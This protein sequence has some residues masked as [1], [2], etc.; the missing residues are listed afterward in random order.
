MSRKANIDRLLSVNA[1]YKIPLLQK[2]FAN[3]QLREADDLLYAEIKSVLE[4]LRSVLDYAFHDLVMITPTISSPGAGDNFYF[5]FAHPRTKTGKAKSKTDILNDFGSKPLVPELKRHHP[6]IYSAL[7]N[8]QGEQ[9]LSDLIVSVND[10]K[11]ND[12][13]KLGEKWMH[14]TPDGT[15]P[16]V[17]AIEGTVF[18]N[19]TF[20][21]GSNA[22]DITI[23]AGGP[24][25]PHLRPFVKIVEEIGET[26]FCDWIHRLTGW[27][28]KVTRLLDTIY[29]HYPV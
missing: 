29:T 10:Q 21:A 17:K 23:K 25:P 11:H 18:E 3:R 26:S 27:N 4:N 1:T 14:V 15:T 7:L 28:A 12:A 20:A 16:V 22:V 9:W 13:V 24:V 6:F 5:P 8:V 2:A 19:C